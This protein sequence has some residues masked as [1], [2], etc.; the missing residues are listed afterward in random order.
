[1]VVKQSNEVEIGILI[2]QRQR[3]RQRPAAGGG[4]RQRETNSIL[5]N[6]AGTELDLLDGS[7]EL[8]S[9]SNQNG[10]N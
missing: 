1:M 9:F 8:H 5:K 4:Q 3:Q 6:M 7:F 10:G 2:W